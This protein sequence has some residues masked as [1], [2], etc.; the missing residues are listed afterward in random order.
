V[1]HL[2][3]KDNKFIKRRILE[4]SPG[5]NLAA[6]YLLILFPFGI[7]NLFIGN[8]SHGLIILTVDLLCILT[9]SSNWFGKYSS[10][11]NAFVAV[12]AVTYAITN[13]IVTMGAMGTYWSFL[14]VVFI[15]FLLP[16]RYA[17]LANIG[18]SLIVL[19]VSWDVLT[20]DVFTRFAAA[21]IGISF[22]IYISSKEIEKAQILLYQQSITDALTGVNNR[23]TLPARLGDAIQSFKEDG[24]KSSLCVLDIDHF[25]KINDT[26]GHD[27]G[28][29]VLVELSRYLLNI[30]SS[31]DTLFR[32]GGEEFLILMSN[33]DADEG[34][35]TAD[36]IRAIVEDLTLADNHQITIS[37]GVTEIEANLSWREWM[38]KSDEKLY[39]AKRNGRNQMVI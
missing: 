9:T 37:A 1:K 26:Y 30:I 12:P 25:K 6:F 33:T 21:L 27:I 36:A 22:F 15:Y 28:D 32:V 14:G 38:K 11:T 16:L 4:I 20:P 19:W 3:K 39:H 18:L 2:P 8:I 7:Y 17:I 24:V 35:K 13:S 10:H 34:S 5:F 31:K 23:T 29:Q